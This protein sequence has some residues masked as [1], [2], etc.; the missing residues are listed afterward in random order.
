MKKKKF[1]SV[2]EHGV[3]LKVSFPVKCLIC[4]FPTISPVFSRSQREKVHVPVLG[5]RVLFGGSSS[6]YEFSFPLDPCSVPDPFCGDSRREDRI[7]NW[8]G[9]QTTSPRSVQR[10]IR[11]LFE[12]VQVQGNLWFTG[13]KL[14]M[15]ASFE[16]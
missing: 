2:R 7:W 5:S 4:Y 1:S 9:R 15:T 11:W 6:T 16:R 10:R 13:A 8:V 14:F 12:R 3:T